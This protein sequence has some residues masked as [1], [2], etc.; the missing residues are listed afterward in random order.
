MKIVLFSP[1]ENYDPRTQLLEY[2][3]RRRLIH[4]IIM[5][6]Q[7]ARRMEIS[8]KPEGSVTIVSIVGNLD[9]ATSPQVNEFLSGQLKT[10]H[11]KMVVDFGQLAYLSSA[12]LR[13][14]LTAV[15]EARRQGGDLRLAAVQSEEVSK[16][17]RMS[18]FSNIF[19]VY[20]DLATAVASFAA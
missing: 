5:A 13:V 11:A 18:G 16:V 2:T 3:N 4:N 1:L 17:L 15:K 10:G 12:G 9:V 6:G 19:K 7:E 8:A 14:L 20:A